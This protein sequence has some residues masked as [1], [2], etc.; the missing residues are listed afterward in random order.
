MRVIW[1]VCDWVVIEH[2]EYIFAHLHKNDYM[3]NMLC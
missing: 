2:C 3:I 1:S